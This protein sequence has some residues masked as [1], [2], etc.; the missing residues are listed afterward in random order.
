MNQTLVQLIFDHQRVTLGEAT[1]A[2]KAAVEDQDMRR[3]WMLFGDPTMRV[4]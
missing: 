3:T 2:A 4:R 1:R